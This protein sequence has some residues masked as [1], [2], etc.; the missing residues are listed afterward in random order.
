MAPATSHSY[1]QTVGDNR[2]YRGGR[3]LNKK[4]TE[5]RQEDEREMHARANCL[6]TWSSGG[7]ISEGGRYLG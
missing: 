2:R 1:G 6:E 5:R 3:Q 7:G 4:R